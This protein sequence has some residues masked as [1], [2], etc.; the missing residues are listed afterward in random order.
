MANALRGGKK[1]YGGRTLI[2]NF[3]EDGAAEG[4]DTTSSQFSTTSMSQQYTVSTKPGRFGAGLYYEK[5][6]PNAN[7]L[8]VIM[9]PQIPRFMISDFFLCWSIGHTHF[10]RLLHLSDERGAC[11]PKEWPEH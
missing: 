10:T 4:R 11:G 6:D 3:V 2:G 8:A 9:L 1:S 7:P 5:P